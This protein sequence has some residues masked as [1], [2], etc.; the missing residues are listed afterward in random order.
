MA[1][2]AASTNLA[3]FKRNGWQVCVSC[4]LFAKQTEARRKTDKSV[5]AINRDH[6]QN[7]RTAAQK[8]PPAGIAAL[9]F[10]GIGM[11][12][13]HFAVIVCSILFRQGYNPTE[14]LTCTISQKNGSGIAHIAMS[15]R[16]LIS[17]P[18]G[19][20]TLHSA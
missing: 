15:S 4:W 6:R 20:L 10:G 17:L 14:C 12:R 18:P 5:R 1:S 8:N 3:L 11:P 7:R 19:Y 9:C 16:R 2:T 13:H